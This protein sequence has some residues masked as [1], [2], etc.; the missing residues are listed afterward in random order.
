MHDVD[1]V[2]DHGR[3]VVNDLPRKSLGLPGFNHFFHVKPL[4]I[5]SSVR[6]WVT[7]FTVTSLKGLEG[8]TKKSFLFPSFRLKEACP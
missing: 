3:A 8:K 1:V 6:P 2:A 5:W 4:N 7:S